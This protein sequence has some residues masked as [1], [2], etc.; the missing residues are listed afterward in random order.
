MAL[1]NRY[2]CR[3]LTTNAPAPDEEQRT[4]PDKEIKSTKGLIFS[5][6]SILFTYYFCYPSLCEV[7]RP[8]EKK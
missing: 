6:H 8:R 5:K 1:D 7:M 2:D 3:L 4:D